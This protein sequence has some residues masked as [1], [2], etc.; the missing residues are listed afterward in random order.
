LEDILIVRH[1]PDVFAKL[2][3]LPSDQ[4]IEFTIDLVPRTQP[5]HK[6][7]YRIASTE[8]RELNEQLQ[9]LLN[10]GYIC[11]SVSSR[12]MPVLFVMKKDGSMRLY[13]DYFELNPITIKNKY[14]LPRINDLF[15]QLKGASIFSKIDLLSGYYQLKV[16]EEDVPK[17]AIQ[18]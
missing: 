7:L 4:E 6:A 11:L 18:T 3:G 13:I 14:P 10:W 16:Q 17:I 12:G 9:E 5:I 15:D 8:L 1:Y 2:T